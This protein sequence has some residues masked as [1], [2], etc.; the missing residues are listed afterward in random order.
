M[1]V[2][3]DRAARHSAEARLGSVG[4]AADPHLAYGDW[5]RQGSRLGMASRTAAW[6]I[7]DW[8]RYGAARYGAKYAVAARV[9]GYDRQTLMNMVYVASRFE[10]S[11]RRE[12]LSFS[13]HAELAALDEDEQEWWLN[14]ASAKKLSVRDLRDELSSL[15]ARARA[16]RGRSGET[17]RARTL[18]RSDSVRSPAR[19]AP[20]RIV[21]CPHCGERFAA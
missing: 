20:D 4:W 2:S 10:F 21:T 9:T 5:L 13:H 18:Q 6:W 1:S 7:G 17:G 14:Q 12:N 8:V 15:S 19:E 11:R 3:L 16:D